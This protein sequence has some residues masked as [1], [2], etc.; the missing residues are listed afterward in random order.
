MK[1]LHLEWIEKAEGDYHTAMREYRARKH[2]NYDAACFHAQQCVEKYFK[3]CLQKNQTYFPKTHDLNTLLDLTVANAPILETY[4][5]EL[6]LLSGYAVEIRYPGESATKEET[7]KIIAIM[8]K[9]RKEFR[10]IVL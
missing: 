10:N 3:A 7:R 9:I 8:K 2:R 1:D 4:R 6:K 5:N